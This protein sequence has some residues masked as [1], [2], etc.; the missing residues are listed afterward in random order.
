MGIPIHF[1]CSSSIFPDFF[2]ATLITEEFY[3]ARA[4]WFA[5][6]PGKICL[7]PDHLL[8]VSSWPR[9]LISWARFTSACAA[10]ERDPRPDPVGFVEI[11]VFFDLRHALLTIFYQLGIIIFRHLKLCGAR[12]QPTTLPEISCGFLIDV[13]A[14]R[15]T[16]ATAASATGS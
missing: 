4:V 11:D 5:A 15:V 7:R 12:L 16:S 6:G 14:L 10:L 9:S 3:Q 8:G 2:S 1:F 13:S